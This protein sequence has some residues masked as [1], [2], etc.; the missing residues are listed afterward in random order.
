MVGACLLVVSTCN[1][2]VERAVLS[3][4]AGGGGF[5]LW[6]SI[7]S[8]LY[9]GL[10]CAWSYAVVVLGS[11]QGGRM[12]AGSTCTLTTTRFIVALYL[13]PRAAV[14]WSL[15]MG[16]WIVW[17]VARHSS[18]RRHPKRDDDAR[19]VAQIM[20][21][22]YTLE[23]ASATLHARPLVQQQQ[24]QQQQPHHQQA[25]A[26]VATATLPPPSREESG[27]GQD[28]MVDIAI[29]QAFQAAKAQQMAGL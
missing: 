27:G 14:V 11:R 4:D 2:E 7:R 3:C 26:G 17:V 16:G 22:L 29:L 28:Q 1:E 13:P 23:E 5:F 8:L 15:L 25:P 21:Q 12:L 10:S 6:M 24:Q 18:M 20:S 19:D 9:T